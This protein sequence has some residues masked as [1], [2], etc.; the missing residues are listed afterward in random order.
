MRKPGRPLDMKRL[1]TGKR[2]LA[3][4]PRQSLALGMPCPEES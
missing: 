3:L 4:R 2:R 1:I